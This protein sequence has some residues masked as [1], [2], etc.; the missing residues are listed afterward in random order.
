MRNLHVLSLILVVMLVSPA[1][2]F[3]K[4]AYQMCED[5]SVVPLSD[6]MLQ[7]YYYIPCPT[8]AW[9][10]NVT[11][12]ESGD[13][14]GVVF[15]IG[16][17]PTGSYLPCSPTDCTVLEQIRVLDFAGYCNYP[18]Y[19]DLC[20]VEIDVYCADEYGCPVGPSLWNSGIYWQMYYGWN[21]LEI[22][23]PITICGCAVDPGPPPSGP[24]IL[25]TATHGGTLATYPAWGFD[26]I[27]TPLE[28]G[29]TMHDYGCLPAGYPRP[30]AGHYSTIHS[31]YY[32]NNFQYCPPQWFKEGGD[33]TPDASQYG[34]MELAW[35]IY[36][37]CPGP[38]HVENTTWGGIKSM[39]R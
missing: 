25:V 7:Y 34:F 8:Y 11:G 26:D 10:W 14:I 13:I 1:L 6:C 31:G 29:C 28:Q 12:W 22:D 2:A 18:R 19:P 17:I 3:E 16:D 21:Y 30:S 9:F 39:Y 15:D 23:P 33:S 5:Y 38:T 4:E 20:T 32:G 37:S 27:S 35:R 36:V 24:R